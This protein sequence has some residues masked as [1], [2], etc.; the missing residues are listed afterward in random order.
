MSISSPS[1]S[2]ASST[3]SP[4]SPVSNSSGSTV[5]YW[6]RNGWGGSHGP[7]GLKRSSQS[8]NGSDLAAA[9]LEPVDCRLDRARDARCSLRGR[10]GARPGSA[11]TAPTASSR[12]RDRDHPRRAGAARARR[13]SRTFRRADRRRERADHIPGRGPRSLRRSRGHSPSPPRARVG[14]PRSRRC[15]RPCPRGSR[16]GSAPRA[17]AA[18]SLAHRRQTRTARSTSSAGSAASSD[19][20]GK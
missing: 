10:S 15:E 11:G 7:C 18:S 20:P 14:R 19:S 6:S 1:S 13:S 16:A 2:D 3:R 9:P 4:S 17:E 12:D 5:M 8:R